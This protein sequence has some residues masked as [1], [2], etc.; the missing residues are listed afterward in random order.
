MHFLLKEKFNH[1][2][3]P[4][5]NLHKLDPPVDHF[6]PVL[7]MKCFLPVRWLTS[8]NANAHPIVEFPASDQH[9]NMINSELL[10]TT[11]I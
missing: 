5:M 1:M 9:S 10:E 6:P 3:V 11:G 4:T 7:H 8:E 2:T